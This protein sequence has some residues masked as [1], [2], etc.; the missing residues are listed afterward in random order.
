MLLD[1]LS[2]EMSGKY[3]ASLPVGAGGVLVSSLVVAGAVSLT[4][5]GAVLVTWYLL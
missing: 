1:G 4:A 3:Q 2:P 5:L